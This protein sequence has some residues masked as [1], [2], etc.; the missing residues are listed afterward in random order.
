MT[1]Q[2]SNPH[3]AYFRKVMARRDNA[4][5]EIRTALPA[6]I[7]SRIDLTDLRLQPGSFVHPDLSNRY[8]DLLYRT[9]L[10]GHPA[11]VYILMEH[12]SSSDRFMAFRMLEYMIAV[13]RQHLADNRRAR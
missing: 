12:Q 1:E 10:D 3:D 11:Y 5:S 8:S 6:A 13:W 7:I 2:R 4:A 9:R